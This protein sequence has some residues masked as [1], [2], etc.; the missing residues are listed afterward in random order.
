MNRFL[1]AETGETEGCPCGPRT[2]RLCREC[3]GD[4]E[5][6]WNC[7][8]KE[9]RPGLILVDP[10]EDWIDEGEPLIHSCNGPVS[11]EEA[12]EHHA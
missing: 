6:C 9:G 12:R 2:Y 11:R 3:G 1:C 7:N 8:A 5:G 4:E 10:D